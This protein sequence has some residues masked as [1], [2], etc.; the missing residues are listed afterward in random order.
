MK[1]N[2]SRGP[3][4]GEWHPITIMEFVELPGEY[5]EAMAWQGCDFAEMEALCRMNAS[6]EV[7]FQAFQ[8]ALR[9]AD[10]EVSVRDEGLGHRGCRII[11]P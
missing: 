2:R 10:V 4:V 11:T 5:L 9:A 7:V 8:T 1:R 3:K 6:V